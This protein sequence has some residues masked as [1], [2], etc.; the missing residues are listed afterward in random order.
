MEPAASTSGGGVL[1]DY[2]GICGGRCTQEEIMA[3]AEIERRCLAWNRITTQTNP[4]EMEARIK[5]KQEG[6]LVLHGM[7]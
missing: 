6:E 3:R 1:L 4:G 2:A 5:F 7:R